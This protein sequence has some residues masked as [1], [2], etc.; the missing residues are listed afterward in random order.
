[1]DMQHARFLPVPRC[2]WLRPSESITCQLR[3]A[4]SILGTDHARLLQAGGD[5]PTHTSGVSLACG[6]PWPLRSHKVLRSGG[7]GGG[8]GVLHPALAMSYPLTGP[9]RLSAEGP[10]Q[11]SV[12][13]CSHT[14]PGKN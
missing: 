9:L 11:L 2:P 4:R 3:H 5:P 12:I 7:G 13:R 14:T 1:M 10:G 8:G 6:H